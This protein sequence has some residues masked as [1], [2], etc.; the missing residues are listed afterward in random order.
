MAKNLALLGL[1]LALASLVLP[2]SSDPSGTLTRG[3]FIGTVTEP[4][5]AIFAGIPAFAALFGATL[6]R[7][8]FGRGLGTLHFLFGAAGLGLAAML[9]THENIQSGAMKLGIGTYALTASAALV[10]VAG[11]IG[12]VKPDPKV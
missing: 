9:F 11:L 2:M 5:I 1:L 12:L 6:G 4:K 10:L 3:A 7:R 8:R